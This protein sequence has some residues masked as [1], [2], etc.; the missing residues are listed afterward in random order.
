M[1][2]DM[3]GGNPDVL[4][5]ID[6]EGDFPDIDDLEGYIEQENY[7]DHT[8][9]DRTYFYRVGNTLSTTFVPCADVD[10]EGAI[11]MRDIIAQAYNRR[12]KHLEGNFTCTVCKENERRG[13]WRKAKFSIDVK[14]KQPR[15]EPREGPS[16]LS[17][18]DRYDLY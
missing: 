9:V 1:A 16:V 14:Y 4:E 15:Q 3:A 18:D 2:T 8:K 5:K 17:P 11:Y 6:M 7:Y 13:K 12:R 10:C